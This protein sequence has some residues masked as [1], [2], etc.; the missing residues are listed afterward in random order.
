MPSDPALYVATPAHRPRRS[1]YHSSLSAYLQRFSKFGTFVVAVLAVIYFLVEAHGIAR[2]PRDAV[3][4]VQPSVWNLASYD[5]MALSGFVFFF[6]AVVRSWNMRDRFHDLVEELVRSEVLL[7]G[8]NRKRF[9]AANRGQFDAA[10]MRSVWKWCL[11]CMAIAMALVLFGFVH[12]GNVHGDQ[13]LLCWTSVLAAA[14]AGER[15]GRLACYARG[16]GLIDKSGGQLC[17]KFWH[18]DNAGGLLP[19]S[20]FYLYT[21]SLAAIPSLWLASWWVGLP[22]LPAD[23]AKVHQT[24]ADWRVT[25]GVMWIAATGMAAFSFVRPILTIH[26]AMERAKD[27]FTSQFAWIPP[28]VTLLH[29]L[30]EKQ[31]D[32]AVGA[33]LQEIDALQKV[34]REAV[35][36]NTWPIDKT[37]VSVFTGLNAAQLLLPLWLKLIVGEPPGWGDALEKLIGKI[38]G[39]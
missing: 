16:T 8:S 26:R 31:K 17:I 36:V 21:M 33:T 18:P 1:A 37:I 11:S 34:Y 19:M 7:A 4:G 29:E 23:F 13:A 39:S 30:A 24:Y 5:L 38:G 10:I 35:A 20:N 2:A 28:R 14:V 3:H 12:T 15:Y 22:H 27:T 6:A 32:D 9:E 25:F